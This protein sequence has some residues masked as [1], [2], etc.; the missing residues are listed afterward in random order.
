MKDTKRNI[1][2]VPFRLFVPLGLLCLIG[3]KSKIL[4]Q[5]LWIQKLYWDESINI[6]L[7]ISWEN[8]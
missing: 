7:D 3:I 8:F 4:L 5:E 6:R 2:S 1:L